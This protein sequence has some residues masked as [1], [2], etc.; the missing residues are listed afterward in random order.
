MIFFIYLYF[1]SSVVVGSIWVYSLAQLDVWSLEKFIGV[2]VT[3]EEFKKIH[4]MG[5]IIS[6]TPFSILIFIFIICEWL[7]KYI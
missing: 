4:T 2:K 6:L 7:K 3:E 1:I 5:V